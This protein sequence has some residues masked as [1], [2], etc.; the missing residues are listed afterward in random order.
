MKKICLAIAACLISIVALADDVTISWSA[1][2]D[3]AAGWNL[4]YNHLQT[5][6]ALQYI[7]SIAPS[8]RSMVFHNISPVGIYQLG[9]SRVEYINDNGTQR[10]IEGPVEVVTIQNGQL[11]TTPNGVSI[12]SVTFS[13]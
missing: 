3:P 7:A 4:Y 1:S 9:I 5:P 12:T 13:Q 11:V 6:D 2:S 10:R 8:N